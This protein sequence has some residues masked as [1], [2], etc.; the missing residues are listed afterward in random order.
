MAKTPKVFISYSHDSPKH[1]EWVLEL[2][3]KLRGNGVDVTLD[4]WDLGPGDDLTRFME[5]GVRDF[6]RVIVICTDNYVKKANDRE[7]GVGYEVQIVSAQL[8]ENLGI[9]KFIPIIRHAS[10]KKKLPTC[11]GARVYIDFTDERQFDEKL[12]ELLH[13]LY[14]VPV[15]EKP[16]LGKSPFVPPS[17]GQE[18]SPSEG[19]D[20]QMPDIPEQVDSALEAYSTA[21]TIARSGDV[22]GWRQLLKRIQPK[23]FKSLVQWRQTELDRQRPESKAQMV[24][25]V[26]RAVEIISPLISVALVGVESGREQFRDQKSLLDD[27]LNIAGWNPAGYTAWANIP[28]ALGYFYHSLHGSLCL[29]TNQLELALGLA[30]VKLP[31]ANGTKY[32]QVWE[33]SEFRGYAESISGTRGGNCM[34]S[35]QYLIDAYEKW[36]W[37][38]YVFGEESEYQTSLVAYYMALSIHELATKI[39][40]GHQETLNIQSEYY[41]S[42]PLTFLCEDYHTTERAVSLLLRNP[43]SLMELWNCLKVTRRQMEESWGN[44]IRLAENQLVRYGLPRPEALVNLSDVFRNLF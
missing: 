44:W 5:V 20:M 39:A 4:Q 32:L 29:S 35:W 42:I 10:G 27:L 11:L 41:F 8:V 23:S 40:S 9:D 17:S 25:V 31:V 7:G 18:A 12:N 30:R 38:S 21:V 13:K 6:D 36:A 33:M 22:F 15:L 43:E 14:E 1:K 37:L 24:K 2:S 28:N 34:E 26:D 3:T 19:L 16:S